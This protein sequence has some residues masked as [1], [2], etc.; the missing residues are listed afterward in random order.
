MS[1]LKCVNTCVSGASGASDETPAP[2]PNSR[3]RVASAAS[4]AASGKLHKPPQ[5]PEGGRFSSITALP[6]RSTS[7]HVRRV[8]TAFLGRAVG[9]S[10]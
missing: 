1:S 8:G 7:I 4:S 9:S 5:I 2:P 6:S 3:A 10:R